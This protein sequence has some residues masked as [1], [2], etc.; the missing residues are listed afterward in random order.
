MIGYAAN[1][2][3][4]GSQG[5]LFNIGQVSLSVKWRQF[6]TLFRDMV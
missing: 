2:L 5:T 1:E 4:S 6:R 3:E